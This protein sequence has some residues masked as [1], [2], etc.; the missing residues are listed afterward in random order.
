MLV[1]IKIHVPYKREPRTF[2]KYFNSTTI[3]LYTIIEFENI[4]RRIN[5]KNYS[6]REITL[7]ILCSVTRKG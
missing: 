1:K 2:P 3:F 6:L 5:D 4:L 7:K